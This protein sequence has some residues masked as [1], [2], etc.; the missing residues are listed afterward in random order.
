MKK[1]ALLFALAAT[2]FGIH[3]AAESELTLDFNI[4]DNGAIVIPATARFNIFSQEGE[5]LANEA[6][7][8]F[9][10]TRNASVHFTLPEYEPGAVFT[11]TP[12][13]G[14]TSVN[15]NGANYVI[16]DEIKLDT[17]LG[18]SFG[19]TVTPLF[20]PPTGRRT[21]SITFHFDV[22]HK[23][24]PVASAA[25][26]NLFDKNG[27]WLANDA[28]NVTKGGERKTLTFS[29][30]EYYTGDI[31]YICPTVG[32]TDVSYNGRTY[33]PNEMIE[34]QTYA[35]TDA[36]GIGRAGNEF[37]LNLTPL[38]RVPQSAPPSA[39]GAAAEAFV[40]NSGVASKTNYLIWVSKKDYKVSVFL[41]SKG[42]WQYVQSFDCA[43]G[44][45]ST[46][47]I[48]GQFEY[49]M[50]QPRWTYDTYYVGPVMRFAKGGYAMHSTLLR[51]NGTPADGRLRMKISHGC[52]RLAPNS[53]NWLADYIPL[54]T[55][56]YITE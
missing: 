35:Y 49:Y 8:I 4:P 11:V 10:D 18:S 16:N 33:Q 31:F 32:M 50:Y 42:N 27:Q 47:T 17:A 39:F 14:I 22:L 38:Y 1:L 25:R 43:I 7:D 44:A 46:P 55:R 45:P 24:T 48:T 30:P 51:Y 54:T 40:N 53:I 20:V 36:N 12:T 9:G 29:L 5:W 19:M 34:V 21:N 41:G 2:V 52:I 13:I 37:H 26:F 28:V 23:G 6:C 15:Y 3:A 56:V